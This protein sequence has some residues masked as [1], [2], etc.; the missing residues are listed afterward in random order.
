MCAWI[1]VGRH[2]VVLL[3]YKNTFVLSS[4]ASFKLTYLNLN[5]SSD[6]F[7]LLRQL[8]MRFSLVLLGLAIVPN[9]LA[10]YFNIDDVY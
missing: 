7:K 9:A 1:N 2:P 5:H 4:F 10:D 8:T 6:H 3:R